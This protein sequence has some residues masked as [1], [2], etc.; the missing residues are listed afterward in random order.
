MTSILPPPLRRLAIQLVRW[1]RIQ[2]VGQVDHAEVVGE[3]SPDANLSRRYLFMIVASCAI[4]TIGLLQ[5][6]P[7]VIIGAMLISPL[8]GPIMGLGFRC[9]SSTWRGCAAR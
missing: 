6:S 8:M 9:A 1:Y 7:A 3:V 4:A 5:N 2:V